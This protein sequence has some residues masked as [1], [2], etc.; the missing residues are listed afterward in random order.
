MNRRSKIT[1]YFLIL[2][3]SIYLR[4]CNESL[5]LEGDNPSVSINDN[6]ETQS[7]T[8]P[9]EVEP[10]EVKPRAY[11]PIEPNLPCLDNFNQ[12]DNGYSP[13]DDYFG[14]GV[15]NNWTQH[16]LTIQTSDENAV[17]LLKDVSSG[18][19]IRNEFIRKNSIFKLT[20]I[21]HGTYKL[22]YYTGLD[23]D[24]YYHVP[25]TS[26]IGGFKC[27]ASFSESSDPSD[28]LR[29]EYS[30]QY[31][32]QYTVTLYKVANGNMETKEINPNS[33]F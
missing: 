8:K 26:I 14:S 22:Q 10:R 16:S 12:P 7:S 17:C 27:D 19:V 5:L 3:V 25:N 13:Y 24:N 32:N 9:R 21:P 33:F 1:L 31:S 20:G 4:H 6:S 28:W 29:F 18:T 2:L 30:E 15:Y 23:W 11:D